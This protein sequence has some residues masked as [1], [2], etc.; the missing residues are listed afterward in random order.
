MATAMRSV[1]ASGTWPARV[2]PKAVDSPASSV[3]PGKRA[4]RSATT[5]ATSS[6]ICAW[7]LRTLAREWASLTDTGSVTLAAP[8]SK[9]ACAPR[10]LGASAA[11][12]RPG[13]SRAAATTSAASAICGS[14]LGGT[15]EQTS[16]SRRPA[17][18][19]APIQRS[20]AGVGMT[21]AMLCNP[22]RGPTS[23]TRIWG[24]DFLLVVL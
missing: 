7:V 19:S 18:A 4:S 14:S 20:L 17:A 5:A 16:I 24:I 13:S 22:S 8:A 15:N 23:L 6:R 12:C 11:T 1:S 3:T 21:A 9:A 2:Q 10:R